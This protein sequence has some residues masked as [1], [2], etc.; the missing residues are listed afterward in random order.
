MA[1]SDC[2]SQQREAFS[3]SCHADLEV[4]KGQ[5]MNVKKALCNQF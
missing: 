4:S 3:E 2:Y 5:S 1:G